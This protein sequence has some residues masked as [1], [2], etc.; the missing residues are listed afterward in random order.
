MVFEQLKK[1]FTH[2][3]ILTK[4]VSDSEMIVETNASDYALAAIIS[5]WT[6][7]SEIHPIAFHSYFFNSA[8]LNYDTHDKELLTIFEAFKHWQ[9]Y[10]EGSRTLINIV[11]DHKNL[12]YF[13]TTKILT[14]W[15][16]HW[17]EYLS[18][19]NMVIHFCPG[20]LGA[21]PDALTRHWDIYHKGGNSDFALANLSNFCSVLTQE[22]L[23][24]SLCATYFSTPIIHSALIIDIEK[25]HNNIHS[26]LPLNPISAAQLPSPSNPKL[27]L[28]ESGLL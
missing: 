26:S 27:T 3:P 28:D 22:Q 25:L 19:F 6:P 14:R 12:E 18:Q 2:A 21:K 10:L 13:A 9:Q 16:A 15:Q 4:W 7:D 24:A 17:S 11:T 20:K 1:E 5:S 23:S 8:E